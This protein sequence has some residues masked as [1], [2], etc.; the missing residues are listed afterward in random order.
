MSGEQF[1]NRDEYSAHDSFIAI[2]NKPSVTSSLVD[3]K[4]H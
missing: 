4:T 3:I 1:S 2:K